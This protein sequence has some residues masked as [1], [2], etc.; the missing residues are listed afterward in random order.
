MHFPKTRQRSLIN[1][2]KAHI[3]PGSWQQERQEKRYQPPQLMAE[4]TQEAAKSVATTM[5]KYICPRHVSGLWIIN[6][7]NAHIAARLLTTERQWSNV[8]CHTCLK[9]TIENRDDWV[10]FKETNRNTQEVKNE[11][12][13]IRTRQKNVLIFGKFGFFDNT[14]NRYKTRHVV[15]R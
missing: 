10:A 13:L 9:K 11:R 8:N 4:Y 6:S 14:T 12:Y 15:Y 2:R 5:G 7:S 3:A 1:P